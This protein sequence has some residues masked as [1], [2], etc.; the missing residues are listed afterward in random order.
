MSSADTEGK[1]LLKNVTFGKTQMQK[2]ALLNNQE[3][4]SQNGD[5]KVQI[6]SI[7]S[8]VILSVGLKYLVP[9]CHKSEPFLRIPIKINC[10]SC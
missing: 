6:N 3:R 5:K 9:N 7:G 1:I 10:N 4:F 2:H 8:V